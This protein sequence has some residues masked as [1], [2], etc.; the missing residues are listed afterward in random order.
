VRDRKRGAVSAGFKV[1]CA[2][3]V[4][5]R[6]TLGTMTP[7]GRSDAGGFEIV[8]PFGFHVPSIRAGVGAP[9]T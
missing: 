9:N 5:T 3:Y 6:Q 4:A 1:T 7:T 8:K 2:S